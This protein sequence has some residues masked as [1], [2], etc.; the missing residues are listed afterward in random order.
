LASKRLLVDEFGRRAQLYALLDRRLL[1]HTR[2]FG[3]AAWTNIALAELF[4]H[5]ARRLW[6]SNL[7]REFLTD[8]GRELQILNA[9]IARTIEASVCDIEDLDRRIVRTEQTAVQLLLDGFRAT[10]SAGAATAITEINR[11]LALTAMRNSAAILHTIG[12]SYGCALRAVEEELGRAIDFGLQSD[13]ECVGITLINGL[14]GVKPAHASRTRS[15]AAKRS[16]MSYLRG[17]R[18]TTAGM[19][20]PRAY[21]V[22]ASDEARARNG[23]ARHTAYQ[24]Y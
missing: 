1:L 21:F 6:I 8:L 23:Y 22:E 20:A 5:P 19:R 9:R 10:N 18:D 12:V 3:A 24:H 16:V 2:F 4:S 15:G 11:L 13:R 17:W 7:T 14:R